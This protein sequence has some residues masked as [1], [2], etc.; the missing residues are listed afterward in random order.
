MAARKKRQA[1][2]QSNRREVGGVGRGQVMLLLSPHTVPEE[3]VP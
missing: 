2:D 3:R 1:E